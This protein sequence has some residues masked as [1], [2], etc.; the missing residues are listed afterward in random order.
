MAFK[1]DKPSWED[2]MLDVKTKLTELITST[3]A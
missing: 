2:A 3:S 1:Y